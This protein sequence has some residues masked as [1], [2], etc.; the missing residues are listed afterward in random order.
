MSVMDETA[1]ADVVF[2]GVDECAPETA[3]SAAY[4]QNEQDVRSRNVEAMQVDAEALDA[5]LE[6]LSQADAEFLDAEEYLQ[7]EAG[8]V[9][10]WDAVSAA[11]GESQQILICV[12]KLLSQT[13][14][15]MGVEDHD[16]IRVYSDVDGAMRLVVDHPRREEIEAALNSPDNVSLRSLYEAA[17][18][19][20]SMAGGLVGK[21]AVPEEVLERVRAKYSAA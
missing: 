9:L 11:L 14:A 1:I 19:G 2:T 15:E 6:L 8:A 4:V 18:T 20:M 17:T 7:P 13:L 16:S 5:F 12:Q 3:E 10:D 21:M